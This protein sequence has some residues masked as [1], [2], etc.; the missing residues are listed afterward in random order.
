MNS[1]QDFSYSP[2]LTVRI[3]Y[4][5]ERY[6]P[7]AFLS[8]FNISPRMSAQQFVRIRVA[9]EGVGFIAFSDIPNQ[10]V[11]HIPLDLNK[12]KKL[13]GLKEY[14]TTNILNDTGQLIISERVYSPIYIRN[15]MVHTL[16]MKA[17]HKLD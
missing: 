4:N 8:N 6:M 3:S 1:V 13:V 12:I 16:L 10:Y 5:H 17:V 15:V 2:K 11:T 9:L 14:S 7:V